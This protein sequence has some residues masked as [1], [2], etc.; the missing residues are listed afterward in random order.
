SARKEEEISLNTGGVTLVQPGP[1]G[2]PCPRADGI[3]DCF[4]TE[5]YRGAVLAKDTGCRNAID[6][7]RGAWRAG[8]QQRRQVQAPRPPQQELRVHPGTAW[9]IRTAIPFATGHATLLRDNVLGVH[10]VRFLGGHAR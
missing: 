6:R 9:R 3:I 4:V 8:G 2:E 10:S 1:D 7:C 5:Y